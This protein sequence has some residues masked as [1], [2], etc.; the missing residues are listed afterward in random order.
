[1]TEGYEIERYWRGQTAMIV[2]KTCKEQGKREMEMY[3]K[4]KKKKLKKT[5]L[6][7]G[8]ETRIDREKPHFRS[9]G[10]RL[11]KD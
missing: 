2:T 10:R 9:M 4:E 5:G 3:R 1:M 8:N 6:G 7:V 11:G